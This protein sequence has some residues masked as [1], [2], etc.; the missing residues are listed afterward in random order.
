MTTKRL[1]AR[2][3]AK[4]LAEIDT[5]LASLRAIE[6][7]FHVFADGN[8]I[9]DA[10]YTA[11]NATHAAISELEYHRGQVELNPRPIPAGELGTAELV[12][13]NID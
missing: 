1:T 9:P 4:A 13:Q 10:I 11:W 2:Q 6:Q 3:L 7:G 8:A 12:W 5:Q